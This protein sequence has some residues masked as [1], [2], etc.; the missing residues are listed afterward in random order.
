M[1]FAKTVIP[2]NIQKTNRFTCEIDFN[3]LDEVSS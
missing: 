1:S 2:E 3:N